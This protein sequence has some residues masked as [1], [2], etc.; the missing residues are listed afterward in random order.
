[1]HS[2]RLS[3]LVRRLQDL[4]RELVVNGLKRI[5]RLIK[6]LEDTYQSCSKPPEIANPR[7]RPIFPTLGLVHYA[8][9]SPLRA[10]NSGKDCLARTRYKKPTHLTGRKH[11]IKQGN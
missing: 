4:L 1:M 3:V 9:G 6:M 11:F 5:S 2:R 10:H 7:A 8:G